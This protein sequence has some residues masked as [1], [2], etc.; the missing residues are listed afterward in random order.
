MRAFSLIRTASCSG[1]GRNVG[2][3]TDARRAEALQLQKY[4][5][6]LNC[7]TPCPVRIGANRIIPTPE[8]SAETAHFASDH[9]TARGQVRAPRTAIVGGLRGDRFTFRARQIIDLPVFFSGWRASGS[10]KDRHKMPQNDTFSSRLFTHQF[11]TKMFLPTDSFLL[12][13]TRLAARVD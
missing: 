11:A 1:S 4:S 10:D 2:E 5:Y 12:P 9:R 3:T 7:P 8:R 6:P 13:R